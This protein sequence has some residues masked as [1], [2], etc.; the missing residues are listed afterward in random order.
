M[1]QFIPAA[2][3]ESDW[4]KQAAQANIGRGIIAI[5]ANKAPMFHV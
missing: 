3:A 4:P 1:P 2:M 5:P